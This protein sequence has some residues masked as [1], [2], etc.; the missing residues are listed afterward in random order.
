VEILLT[1]W[2]PPYEK[3]G[4]KQ[5]ADV[6]GIVLCA[7]VPGIV[8]CADVLGMILCAEVPGIVLW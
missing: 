1:V 7:D 4:N 5:I 6:P 2:H 8:L 3:E